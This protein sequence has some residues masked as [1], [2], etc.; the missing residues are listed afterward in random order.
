[1]RFSTRSRYGLRFLLHLAVK[2]KEGVALSLQAIAKAEQI[3]SGYL[4]QI[5]HALRP[6]GVLQAVRGVGGGY[7]LAKEPNSVCLDTVLSAL[8]GDLVSLDCLHNDTVCERRFSCTTHFFWFDFEQA[9]RCYLHRITLQTLL[10]WQRPYWEEKSMWEYTQA[11]HDHFLHP[12]NAGPL[13]DANAIGEVG[14]LAC[15]DALRLYLK[16]N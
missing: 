14:S 8:E 10:D 7:T 12:H 11:V 2:K 13:K 4:E 6:L 3:S 15:G 9:I 5:V 1:M 16:I